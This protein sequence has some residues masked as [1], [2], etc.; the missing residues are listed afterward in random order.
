MGWF[1]SLWA[2]F[3]RR[4]IT[5][6][7]EESPVV[8]PERTVALGEAPRARTRPRASEDTSLPMFRASAMDRPTASGSGSALSSARLALNHVFT[9]AQPV[10]ERKR[11]AGR[12]ETLV[13]LISALED[14]RGHVVLYGERG[15][16]KTSLLHVLSE[17]ARDSRYH[18]AYASCG[19]STRFDEIFRTILAEMPLIYSSSVDPASHDLVAG[20]TLDTLL[21]QETFDARLLGDVCASITGTRL[22][23]ILDEYDRTE[24]LVFRHNVAELIKNLSD[25]AARVQLVIA[26]VAGNLQELVGY[27]PSIRRNVIGLPVP[28]LERREV[29]ALIALGER[30]AGL[31]FTPAAV[32]R[33]NHLCNGSP[34]LVRLL[35][36]QAGLTAHS[37]R[38]K[39][40]VLPVDRDR[41]GDVGANAL[42]KS[43]EVPVDG[44]IFILVASALESVLPTIVSRCQVVPFVQVRGLVIEHHLQANHAADPARARELARVADGRIGW[45]I[46]AARDVERDES[47]P[48]EA[49]SELDWM[50][51]AEARSE[52]PLDEQAVLLET[53]LVHARDMIVWSRTERRDWLARPDL[54]EKWAS[55]RDVD[56]WF[57]VVQALEDTRRALL[58]GGNPRVWWASLGV[59]MARSV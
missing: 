24:D 8:E 43:I 47:V 59:R 27:I 19:G 35:C 6:E 3:R 30:E 37:G 56:Q 2:R 46:R 42:L 7:A 58:A 25:R 34:Y 36:H 11:F 31:S 20:A 44:T 16:G 39:I 57:S 41:L 4:P 22:L 29:E 15:I 51:S 50:L 33:V 53:W 45:A 52:L 48:W 9:P 40:F 13:Q 55:S 23:I 32:D 26:G 5:A 21:P 54:T 10:T 38:H 49:R 1:R 18:V 28:R 12:L 17:I 14:K